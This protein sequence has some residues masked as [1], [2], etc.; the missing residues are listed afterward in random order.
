[1]KVATPFGKVN[2]MKILIQNGY[3]LDPAS[4]SEGIKDVLVENEKI[5]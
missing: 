1:M 5:R 4:K 3:V 2:T